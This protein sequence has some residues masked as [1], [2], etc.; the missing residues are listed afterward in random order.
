MISDTTIISTCRGRFSE[1]CNSIESWMKLEPHE[2]VVVDA[3]CPDRTGERLRSAY[4]Q[5]KVWF[6]K[7]DTFSLARAKNIGAR[8]ATGRSLLFLDADIIV[9]EALRSFVGKFE[10]EIEY[11]CIRKRE[12]VLVPGLGGIILCSAEW[13]RKLDGYDEVLVG[14]GGED[15]ELLARLSLG[16]LRRAEI[17]WES[18]RHQNHADDER[19]QVYKSYIT[20]TTII[21][22]LY[23]EL[24]SVAMLLSGAQ[25]IPI[26]QRQCLYNHVVE[27]FRCGGLRLKPKPDLT[28]MLP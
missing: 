13:F 17:P 21:N 10:G 2:I 16:G 19:Q 1:L 23:T 22:H 6:D 26:T 12:S 20:E 18:V 5:V 15:S 24:K 4:P 25:A 28:W 27:S 8:A 9:S 11:A 14:Y 7:E 3:H